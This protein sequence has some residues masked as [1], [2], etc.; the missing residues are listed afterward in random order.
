M[1]DYEKTKR[2]VLP[3]GK[4][5][6][7][8]GGSRLGPTGGRRDASITSKVGV[9]SNADIAT[10]RMDKVPTEFSR[11]NMKRMIDAG[12]IDMNEISELGAKLVYEDDIDDSKT[13]VYYGNK[14]YPKNSQLFPGDIVELVSDDKR[15]NG[16]LAQ[17]NHVRSFVDWTI[18]VR[19]RDPESDYFNTKMILTVDEYKVV[20]RLNG[21]LSPR[22][23]IAKVRTNLLKEDDDNIDKI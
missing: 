13:Y 19:I 17:V 10:T 2:K 5:Q 22:D 23:Y 20:R 4:F 9:I 16:L 18:S 14:R 3:D 15:K 8:V 12:V 6:Y 11:A 7:T 1:S 21:E